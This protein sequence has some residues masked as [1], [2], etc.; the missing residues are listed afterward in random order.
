MRFTNMAIRYTTRTVVDIR[1]PR[2][3]YSLHA[4]NANISL[5]QPSWW[6]DDCRCF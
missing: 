6:R 2:G 5:C 1:N 3:S 4:A